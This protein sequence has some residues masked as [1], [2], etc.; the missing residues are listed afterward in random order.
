M[1]WGWGWGRGW[2]VVCGAALSSSQ[3]Q[4]ATITRGM[5][6]PYKGLINTLRH[7]DMHFVVLCKQ[8]RAWQAA[9]LHL[10]AAGCPAPQS[11]SPAGTA[12]AGC[13]H[14]APATA[15][16]PSVHHRGARAPE[17]ALP[18]APAAASPGQQGLGVRLLPP[19]QAPPPPASLQ[20][21]RQLLSR[22][23]LYSLAARFARPRPPWAP[24]ALG[25]CLACKECQSAS[26]G[27]I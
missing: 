10:P 16:A 21:Q 9:A 26:L 23:P 5:V 13:L 3:A 11:S 6:E 19:Q 27:P 7:A 22:S 17:A 20:R 25:V 15:A 18:D 14:A 4:R 24:Q 1:G 8:Q 2:G 12:A